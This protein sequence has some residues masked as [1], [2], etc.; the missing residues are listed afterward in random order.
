MLSKL[1]VLNHF[2]N[3]NNRQPPNKYYNIDKPINFEKNTNTEYIEHNFTIFETLYPIH[4]LY[5]KKP[6]CISS[7][8]IHAVSISKNTLEK[9][10]EK[11]V[12]NNE[13]H[14]YYIEPVQMY[15]YDNNEFSNIYNMELYGYYKKND[16][17]KYE[18][19]LLFINKEDKY[20]LDLYKKIKFDKFY[21]DSII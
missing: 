12:P 8:A 4:A 7:N 11:H 16:V 2:V 19:I 17:N 20:K 13:K 3:S 6:S 10:L 14:L 5:S 9:I 21:E 18:Q 1:N 15:K